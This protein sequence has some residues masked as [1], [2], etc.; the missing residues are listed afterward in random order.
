M[1][2]KKTTQKTAKKAPKPKAKQDEPIKP[3]WETGFHKPTLE[4][5]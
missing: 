3:T 2:T 5:K 4:G 1:T